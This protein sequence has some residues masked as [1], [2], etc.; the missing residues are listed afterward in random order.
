MMKDKMAIW[1]ALLAAPTTT[2]ALESDPGGIVA[3]SF[4][5]GAVGGFVGALLACWLCS[6]RNRGSGD[7]PPPKKY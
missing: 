3:Y 6:R 5:G 1:A 2:F 7:Q 4:V